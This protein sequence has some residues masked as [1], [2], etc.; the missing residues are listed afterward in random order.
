MHIANTVE[1][2]RRRVAQWKAQGLTLGLTPTMGYLHEGHESLIREARRLTDR[3]IVSIFVN[4]T[5]FGPGEDLARYPRDMERDLDI[6]KRNQADLVFAPSAEAMYPGGY[7]TYVDVLE[8]SK[9]LCGG[10]RP[11]HFRGVCTVVCKLFNILSPD[12]AFFGQKDAQ[13]L[14]VIKRMATDLELPIKIIGCPIVREPDGLAKSS[15]NAYLNPEE[16]KAALA[17][18]RGLALAK[19]KA[20]RGERD[21]SALKALI[22]KELEANPLVRADYVEIVSAADLKPLERLSG[23]VLIAVAAFVGKTRLI[24][25]CLLSVESISH[26][27]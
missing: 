22:R 20:E 21:G 16:R 4:P 1:E 13:Q 3:V 6:C 7:Q 25:N 27:Q 19:E 8:L 5:Q 2:A 12:L 10:S 15:R 11:G 14:A 17:L 9:G 26:M 18:S 24:D 23:E